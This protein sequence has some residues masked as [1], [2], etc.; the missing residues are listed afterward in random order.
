MINYYHF[1]GINKKK[2]DENDSKIIIIKII[3]LFLF[4]YFSI[5]NYFQIQIILTTKIGKQYKKNNTFIKNDLLSIKG[6]TYIDID[7][8]YY[9]YEKNIDFSNFTTDIKT[10]AFYSP[11][12]FYKEN[13]NNQSY[14]LN[15][16]SKYKGHNQPRKP[17]DDESYLLNGTSSYLEIIQ[18]QV[19]L[20][21]SHGIYGFAIYYYWSIDKI[22][23][24]KPLK[25]ILENKNIDFPFFLVWKN[26]NYSN[27]NIFNMTLESNK[28][29]D[30]IK[31]YII[32]VRYIKINEKP[33]IGIYGNYKDNI[34][35]NII[36]NWRKKSN[37]YGIGE[38]YILINLN[39]FI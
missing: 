1:I 20:A 19:K 34:Y 17:L 21:K 13:L 33:V 23:F 25:I 7:N 5:K 2:N 26:K 36:E 29:I 31:L 15:A 38:I 9:L 35:K 24:E 10:I 11:E 28:F 12:F 39:D 37:E 18:K 16:K 3:L 30:D 14:I 4:N 32:D 6:R 27:N 22:F 8:L